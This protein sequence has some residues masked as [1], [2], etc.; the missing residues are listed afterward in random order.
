MASK[1]GLLSTLGMIAVGFTTSLA[2]VQVSA[3]SAND[4]CAL[5]DAIPSAAAF[6]AN[7][8]VV[9]IYNDPAH[10]CYLIARA[11]LAELRQAVLIQQTFTS[12]SEPTG[13]S[14]L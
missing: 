11:K 3:Q 4:L 7:A 9:A 14:L 10:P 6:E 12:I 8:N 5:I 1:K 13:Y 2:P